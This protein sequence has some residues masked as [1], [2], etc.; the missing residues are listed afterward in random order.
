[1]NP[2]KFIPAHESAIAFVVTWHGNGQY[3]RRTVPIVAWK[4]WPIGDGN[5]VAKPIFTIALDPRNTR[6]GVH[7]RYGVIAD[8]RIYADQGDFERGSVEMFQRNNG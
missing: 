6:V 7:T 1:M 4:L 3:E 5:Y 2:H 8:N